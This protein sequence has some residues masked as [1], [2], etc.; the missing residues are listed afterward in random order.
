MLW[1][2]ENRVLSEMLGSKNRDAGN[3][4]RRSF[5]IGL[6][7][8]HQIFWSAQI[9]EN[10]MEWANGT[11]GEKVLNAYKAFFFFFTYITCISIQSKFLHLPTDVQLNFLKNNF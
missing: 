4:T 2:L 8:S 11:Y 6:R 5:M 3:C 1:V 10:S 7:P 9:T